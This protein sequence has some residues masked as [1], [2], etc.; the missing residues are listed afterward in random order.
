MIL[1]GFTWIGYNQYHLTPLITMSTWWHALPT[2]TQIFYGIGFVALLFTA[3]QLL[4]ALVGL[5]GDVDV[6]M[7]IDN[8]DAHHSS[9]IGLFSSHTIAAFLLGFGWIGGI[10]RA[11]GL[12]LHWVVLLAFVVGVALMFLMAFMLRSLLRLQAKGNLDYRTAIGQ[13]GVVNVTIPGGNQD[14]G[15]Q[16][17]VM[18][19]GRWRVAAA[20]KITGGALRPGEKVRIVDTPGPA[21]F[22]VESSG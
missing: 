10:T 17:Q 11:A 6:D 8:P 22:I 5:G 3:V 20:R 1:P 12:E 14:G 2:D 15:G 21:S 7:D 16:I 19:Q 13:E 18:I 4:I 9:G